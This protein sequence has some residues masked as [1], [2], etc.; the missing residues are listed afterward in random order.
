MKMPRPMHPKMVQRAQLVKEAHAHLSA[1][2]PEY[3][4]ASPRQRM[5]LVQQ[6][7]ESR[8]RGKPK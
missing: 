8:F 6:H 4:M 7:V 1:A 3:K 2:V 5:M